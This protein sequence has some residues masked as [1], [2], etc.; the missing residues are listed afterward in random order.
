MKVVIVIDGESAEDLAAV[1]TGDL[2]NH[3][4][5]KGLKVNKKDIAKIQIE[6]IKNKEG[7]I[8]SVSEAYFG[9]ESNATK[10]SD[11]YE[12]AKEL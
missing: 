2:L 1:G 5:P 4:L 3:F 10:Y 6:E 7:K 9:S 12:R 11:I 8:I